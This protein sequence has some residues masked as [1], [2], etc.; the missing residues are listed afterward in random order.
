[1]YHSDILTLCMK[2]VFSALFCGFLVCL[3][4]SVFHSSRPLADLAM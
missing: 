4:R 1:M 3:G 2:L